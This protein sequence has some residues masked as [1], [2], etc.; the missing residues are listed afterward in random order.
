MPKVDGDG[1]ARRGVQISFVS[2]V[3]GLLVWMLMPS[4]GGSGLSPRSVCAANLRGIMQSMNV[5]ANDNADAYPIVA[6][7]P[8]SPGLNE[9]RAATGPSNEVD[10]IRA[11]YASPPHQA[12]SVQAILWQLVLR[13][14]VATK[15]FIC[16]S[17]RSKSRALEAP[18]KN[19]AGNCFDNFQSGRQLSYS[20]AY[21][22][23]PDG[24]VGRWWTST[25]DASL[26]LMSDMAPEQ[27][28]GAPAVDVTALTK[29]SSNSRNHERDGQNVAFGD[30]HV[31][32]A[33]LPNIGQGNDN[34]FTV[35]ATPSTGPSATGI[36]ATKVSPV[37]TADKAPFDIV[38]YP[39]RNETTGG[40]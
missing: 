31:E 35:S 17:E 40:F 36:P 7:A 30:A 18:M 15:S 20:V 4:T 21:P 19:A 6:Y 24:T 23:K 34:I 13:G 10:V 37:L 39:I 3:L 28:T 32:F 27:G 22:W 1:Y 38:M 16:P 25:V 14:D 33:R 26:P 2:F 12:G 11:Y 5:Y 29:D 9:A 8:F